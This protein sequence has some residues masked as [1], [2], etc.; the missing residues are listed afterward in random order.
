MVE[1]QLSALP[2]GR[3]LLTV[4]A[5][6][7]GG[8]AAAVIAAFVTP[9]VVARWWSAQL[10][11]GSAPGDPFVA[12]FP[13]LGQTM[14]GEV[15]AH[16]PG[17]RL[18]FTWSWDHEPERPVYRV[19]V[20]ASDGEPARL[21]LTHGPYIDDEPGRADAESHRAGWEYFLPRLLAEVGGAPSHMRA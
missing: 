2:D 13:G 6:V 18:A 1:S 16:D 20:E 5:S 17:G 7:A 15:V 12:S 10:T 4:E 9:E 3:L 8:S 21:T 11:I 14:R 19:V